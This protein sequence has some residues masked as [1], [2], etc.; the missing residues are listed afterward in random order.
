MLTMSQ[1]NE[2]VMVMGGP[3]NEMTVLMKGHPHNVAMQTKVP[4][5]IR[6]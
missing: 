6:L 5:V 4:I 1:T 2:V 3:N